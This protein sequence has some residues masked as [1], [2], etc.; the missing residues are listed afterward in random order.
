MRYLVLGPGG[1][2]MYSIFGFIKRMEEKGMLTDLQEIS[3][4]SA[5]ALAAFCFLTRMTTEQMLAVDNRSLSK[6]SIRHL[7]KTGGLINTSFSRDILVKISNQTF[8]EM[9][10][11]CGIKL[12]ISALSI[13][14]GYTDSFSVDTTPN[15][16]VADAVI[17]SI[18]IPLLFPPH[19][20]YLDGSIVEE[21]PATPFLKYPDDEILI[22]KITMENTETKGPMKTILQL[23]VLLCNMRSKYIGPCVNIDIPPKLNILDFKMKHDDKLR[24]YLLGYSH[25]YLA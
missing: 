18:S 9:Y 2:A 15:M 10:S 24:L 20:G 3:G 12:H 4:S 8:A 13:E 11:S 17:A 21:I 1:V 25:C 16:I 19:N 7:L 23:A 5:G 14:K 6:F 22:V